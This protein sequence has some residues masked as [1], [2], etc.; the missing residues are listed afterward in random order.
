M[1]CYSQDGI[2]QKDFR[3]WD[4]MGIFWVTQLRV[5]LPKISPSNPNGETFSPNTALAVTSHKENKPRKSK[6]R[7]KI[8]KKRL[9]DQGVKSEL[10]QISPYNPN[11]ENLSDKYRL[12]RNTP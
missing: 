2:W 7:K 8:Q 5:E 3:H 9:A 11:V 12:G 10:P 6:R 1:A 4:Y